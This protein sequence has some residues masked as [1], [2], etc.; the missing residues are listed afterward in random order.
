[1]RAQLSKSLRCPR[2]QIRP[3]TL[4]PP[5]STLPIG[6]GGVRPFSA[7]QGSDRNCQSRALPIFCIQTRESVTC[8]TRSS[9]PASVSSTLT[10]GLAASWLATLPPDAPLP[11]TINS[12]TFPFCIFM[13]PVSENGRNDFPRPAPCS[14]G[15]NSHAT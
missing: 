12:Y 2:A 14:L 13:L 5:P 1:A 6:K 7:A 3:L 15:S 4:L 11:Q 10:S 9:S 8:G